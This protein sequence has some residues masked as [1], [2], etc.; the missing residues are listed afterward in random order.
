MGLTPPSPSAFR[1]LTTAFT[2]RAFPRCRCPENT[3]A[4]TVRTFLVAAA[5]FAVSPGHDFSLLL[6][7]RLSIDRFGVA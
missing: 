7:V 1:A 4:C 5:L 6:G 2:L 3:L